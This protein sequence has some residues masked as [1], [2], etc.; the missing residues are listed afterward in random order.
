MANFTTE[1]FQNHILRDTCQVTYHQN[2]NL[3]II[4]RGGSKCGT[5]N[6][7]TNRHSK[8]T[9]FCLNRFIG[10]LRNIPLHWRKYFFASIKFVLQKSWEKFAFF[11][12]FLLNFAWLEI[13]NFLKTKVFFFLS[14]YITLTFDFLWE[15]FLLGRLK[16]IFFF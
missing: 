3:P 4:K 5:K 6:W 13:K 8:R 16:N 11:S 7:N 2:Y 10:K 14:E 15:I 9:T 1:K 12:F